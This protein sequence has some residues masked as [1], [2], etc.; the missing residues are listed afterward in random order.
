MLARPASFG[1]AMNLLLVEDD[2]VD[3]LTVRRAV[4]KSQTASRLWVAG[5]GLE[6]LG[7]LRGAIFPTDR[8]L[9]LLDL[10]LP[11]MSGLELLREMRRDPALRGIPAVVLSSADDDRRHIERARLTVAGYLA[12][13]VSAVALIEAVLALRRYGVYAE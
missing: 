1:L 11:R 7:L 4:E 3:V 9:V 8:R 13:P 6:A 12:K 5:D 2:E 10:H